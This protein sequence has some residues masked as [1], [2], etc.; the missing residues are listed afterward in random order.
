VETNG[1]AEGKR[2]KN[3]ARKKTYGERNT[4]VQRNKYMYMMEKEEGCTQQTIFHLQYVFPKKTQPSLT[5]S[6][7]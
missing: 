7:N 1:K 6:I 4:V 5:S 3:M 2:G